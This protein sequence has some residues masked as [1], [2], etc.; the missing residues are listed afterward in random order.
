M[1]NT[2]FKP[3]EQLPQ[4]WKRRIN[5]NL[6]GNPWYHLQAHILHITTIVTHCH[7]F[8]PQSSTTQSVNVHTS[9]GK[10]STYYSTYHLQWVPAIINSNNCPW[11]ESDDLPI[12]N[13]SAA[14]CR[15]GSYSYV[16]LESTTI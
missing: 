10:V 12:V 15:T 14:P 9:V 4:Q 1:N 16:L 3:S 6:Y 8:S 13:S 5:Q 7:V 11:F 2:A